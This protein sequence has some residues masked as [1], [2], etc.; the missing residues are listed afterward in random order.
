VS[1]R[2]LASSPF[3]VPSTPRPVK[4][5]AVDDRVTHDTYGMGTVIRVEEGVAVS[6]DFGAQQVR[7]LAPFG[8]LTKL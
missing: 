4:E 7:V 3:N 1:R 2:P 8:K 6:V 5:F